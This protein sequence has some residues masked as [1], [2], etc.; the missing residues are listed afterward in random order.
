M[1]F[2][3]SY[4]VS[5]DGSPID[6]S[7]AAEIEVCFEGRISCSS[8][9]VSVTNLHK[10][11]LL[12]SDVRSRNDKILDTQRASLLFQGAEVPFT[13]KCGSKFNPEYVAK[14]CDVKI[15]ESLELP[16]WFEVCTKENIAYPQATGVVEPREDFACEAVEQVFVG[17][18]L[19]V[20]SENG[21]VPCRILNSSP[22]RGRNT[23]GTMKPC[24]NNIHME[25]SRYILPS[26]PSSRV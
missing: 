20:L 17:A 25:R 1:K 2:D 12:G 4:L 26:T 16:S 10:N 3:I 24:V 5:A 7:G 11:F 18:A 8:P 13:R 19:V 14:C 6:V 23:C 15:E 21:E 9:V 22:Q